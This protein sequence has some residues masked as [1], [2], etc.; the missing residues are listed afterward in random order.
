MV[1]GNI[2]KQRITDFYELEIPPE[3]IFLITFFFEIE[4]CRSRKV[5]CKNVGLVWESA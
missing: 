4:K 3:I 1:E 5:T 2:V